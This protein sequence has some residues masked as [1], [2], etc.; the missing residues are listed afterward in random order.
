M[1]KEKITNREALK[2]ALDG[3]I[4]DDWLYF[5]YDKNLT[6]E[7]NSEKYDKHVYERKMEILAVDYDICLDEEEDALDS[8]EHK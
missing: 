8:S 4:L 2:E 5:P 3:I 6:I 1:S 7:E